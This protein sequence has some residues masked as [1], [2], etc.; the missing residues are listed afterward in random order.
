MASVERN[1]LQCG[2]TFF[3][4]PSYIRRGKGKFCSISC[5]TT[6]RNLTDNPAWRDE[7]KK[8]ISENHAPVP[9]LFDYR[10]N[11]YKG[12]DV[13]HYRK[14]ALRYYG[15]SCNR[16]GINENLQVHHKDRNRSNN[17]LD[18]LEVLCYDCHSEEH[19]NEFKRERCPETGRFLSEEKESDVHV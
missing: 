19:K 4:F 18:N 9:W 10:F 7:V 1:C 12:I 17:E 16:C 2:T 13:K 11:N 14:K 3:T 6:Y 15:D 8:K 5:G